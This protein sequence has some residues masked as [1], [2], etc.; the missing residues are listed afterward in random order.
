[1]L[2]LLPGEGLSDTGFLVICSPVTIVVAC[3]ILAFEIT[4]SGTGELNILT[5]VHPLNRQQQQQQPSQ[6]GVTSGECSG[7]DFGPPLPIHRFG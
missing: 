2:C 1:M 6:E 4:V 7:H 3:V 5:F